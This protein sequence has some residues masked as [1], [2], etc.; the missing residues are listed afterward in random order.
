MDCTEVQEALREIADPEIAE[1]SQRFF[2]TGP[3]EYGED[4]KFLGIRVPNIRKVAQRFKQLSL[5]ETELLLHSDYHE[6]CLCALIILVN[7]AKKA[8]S[9]VKKEIFEL[10]L[11]NL[12]YINNWDLVDTSA[13]HIVGTYL[14]DNDRSILYQLAKSENL[15]ERRIAIISTFHFIK[16]DDFED[17]LNIA[18]L[19]LNDEHDLIH[20][21]VGWMLREVGKRDINVEERFLNQYI[22]LMPRTMLRYAIEKFPEEKRQHYLNM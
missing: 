6:E 1:H 5:G 15:W 22:K 21:A 18:K 2:K 8:N 20:K 3:G 4:D 14:S 10:Y 16:N 12:K 19:L 17:T 7:R 11:S 9:K 13:E